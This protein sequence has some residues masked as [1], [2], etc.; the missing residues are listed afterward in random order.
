MNFLGSFL[1]G[2]MDDSVPPAT[3]ISASAKP[4]T[5][6][7]N[8]NVMV[9]ASPAFSALTSLVIVTEGAVLSTVMLNGSLASEMLPAGPMLFAVMALSPSTSAVENVKLQSPLP[10]TAASPALVPPT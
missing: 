8:V 4:A 3:S 5:S 7:P 1:S 10:S 9:A 6:S 2:S